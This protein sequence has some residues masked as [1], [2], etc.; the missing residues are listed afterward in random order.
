MRKT[1]IELPKLTEAQLD[2]VLQRYAAGQSVKKIVA[3]T[4]A[5]YTAVY[6]HTVGGG[7]ILSSGSA[8]VCRCGAEHYAAGLCKPCYYRAYRARRRAAILMAAKR[9]A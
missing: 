4:K 7:R 8:R 1:N 9:T 5:A 2:D 3:E 6:F